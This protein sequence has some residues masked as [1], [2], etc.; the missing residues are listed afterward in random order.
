MAA[1]VVAVPSIVVSPI[2]A[3]GGNPSVP[4]CCMGRRF[5]LRYPRHKAITNSR[6][7]ISS[8]HTITLRHSSARLE[9]QCQQDAARTCVEKT[10]T[11]SIT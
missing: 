8:R 2:F 7:R 11:V 10:S 1:P 9:P 4:T 6:A 3:L 5:S